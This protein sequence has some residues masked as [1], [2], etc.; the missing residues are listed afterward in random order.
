VKQNCSLILFYF[1][2]SKDFSIAI[3]TKPDFP[4]LLGKHLDKF[5][6]LSKTRT[7]PGKLLIPALPT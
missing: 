4:R 2:Y 6:K 5:P 1:N 7:N 3:I